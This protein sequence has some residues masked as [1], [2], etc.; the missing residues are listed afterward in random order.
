LP[1]LMKTYKNDI[2]GTDQ[3]LLEFMFRYLE[4]DS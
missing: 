1:S 2:G 4:S 3:L